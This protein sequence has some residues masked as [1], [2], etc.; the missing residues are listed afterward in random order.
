MAFL[1]FCILNSV[2]RQMYW[3]WISLDISVLGCKLELVEGFQVVLIT[4]K[5]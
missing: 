5:E 1:A 3:K 4:L 2:S